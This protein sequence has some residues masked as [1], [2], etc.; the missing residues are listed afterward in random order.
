MKKISKYWSLFSVQVVNALAYPG[1]L[2]WRSL[3]IVLFMW[4]FASLWRVTYSAAGSESL[5]GLT[6]PA[7]LW[8]LMM[9]ETIELSK[10]RLSRA[11]SEQVKDG[12]VAYILNKPYNFLLYQ[13][14]ISLGDSVLRAAM[15][16]LLGGAIVWIMIGPPPGLLGWL[17][18]LVGMLGA[19]L[20]HF[21]INAM[22]G[23]AAFVAEDVEP[24]DWIYQKFVFILGGLLIPLS[25]YP[26]WLQDITRSLP[27]SFMVYEPARLFVDPDPI[28]FVNMLLGQL[29]WLVILGG[30][31]AIFYRRGVRRL[32]INGG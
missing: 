17:M 18:G 11:I 30:L 22:I 8:Y 23:L 2:F 15:N 9:A 20:L 16:A 21:C 27:F 14:S 12:S 6:L 3:G 5:G 25:L 1:E 19:W 26:D 28:R 31:L 13:L 29:A 10:P 32:A 4:V 7:M 24:F